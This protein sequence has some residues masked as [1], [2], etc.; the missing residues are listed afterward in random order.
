MPETTT[1]TSNTTVTVDGQQTASETQAAPLEFDTWIAAQPEPVKAAIESHTKGLK[2][3]LEGERN[4]RKQLETQLREMAGK[5]EKGSETQAQLTQLADT[6]KG[7]TARADF[8]EAAHAAGVTNL[9]L[10]YLVATADQLF[11]R[12][13]SP[14]FAA[15]K[16]SYPELFAGAKRPP[17]G[18]AG[19]GTNKPPTGQ[20]MNDAIRRASGRQ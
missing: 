16:A 13:G 11:D 14:D 19:A 15:L 9:K 20:S 17:A 18:D 8:Y 1:N 5:A 10:A 7:E 4:G 6:V 2:S 3:A 12:K